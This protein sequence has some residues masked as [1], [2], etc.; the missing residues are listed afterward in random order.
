M[1][2]WYRRCMRKLPLDLLRPASH[3]RLQASDS[4]PIASKWPPVAKAFLKQHPCPTSAQVDD[5]TESMA[6][7]DNSEIRQEAQ[8]LLYR[9]NLLRKLLSVDQTKSNE[10]I[11][12][13][14]YRELLDSRERQAEPDGDPAFAALEP[15]QSLAGSSDEEEF[16]ASPAVPLKAAGSSFQFPPERE[17]LSDRD[18]L[19]R[20]GGG[21]R[22]RRRTDRSMASSSRSG[23]EIIEVIPQPI[24]INHRLMMSRPPARGVDPFDEDGRPPARKEA[25]EDAISRQA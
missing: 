22:F 2:K 17:Q 23:T 5:I 12:V 24:V 15:S 7:I 9:T 14:E 16:E 3:S 20:G 1:L 25:A 8:L 19:Q 21:G 4:L 11:S 18:Q 10:A 6:L 13:G